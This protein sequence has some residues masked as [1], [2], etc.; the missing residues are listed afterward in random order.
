MIKLGDFG[1]AR[2]LTHTRENAKSIVGTPYYLAPEII[3]NKAY[4]FKVDIWSLGIML[5]EMCALKPPFDADSLHA[6]ALKIVRGNYGSLPSRY[7]ADLKRLLD[8]LLKVNQRERPNINAV[9]K[10]KLL[11]GRVKKFLSDAQF[12]SEFSHTVLHKEN[13]FSTPKPE[14]PAKAKIPKSQFSP[15]P[16]D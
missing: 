8:Q 16:Q 10:Q 2:V 5:F 3:E 4:N 7:S 14:A 6:L 11:A 12:L 13:V 1:I 9:L 15:Q